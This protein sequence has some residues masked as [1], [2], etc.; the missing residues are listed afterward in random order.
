MMMFV[1]GDIL[2][3][4]A[5]CPPAF[6]INGLFTTLL[7]VR[8]AELEAQAGVPNPNAWDTG[9]AEPGVPMDVDRELSDTEFCS[10]DARW[11]QQWLERISLTPSQ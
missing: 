11:R 3:A 6:V 8:Q 5:T 9:A 7:R 4:A 1:N 10:A 2:L